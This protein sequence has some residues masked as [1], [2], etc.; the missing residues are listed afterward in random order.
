MIFCVPHI[1]TQFRPVERSAGQPVSAYWIITTVATIPL[2]S[3]LVSPGRQWV[4]DFTQFEGWMLNHTVPFAL[5]SMI[6]A[7]VRYLSP[8]NLSWIE[9]NY[10]YDGYFMGSAFDMQYYDHAKVLDAGAASWWTRLYGEN[11]RQVP[12]EFRRV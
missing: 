8:S 4:A 12:F 11:V 6:G 10:C 3:A 1:T 2:V 9:N 7:T 5:S